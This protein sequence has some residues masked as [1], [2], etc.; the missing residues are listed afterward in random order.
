LQGRSGEKRKQGFYLE[1]VFPTGEKEPRLLYLEVFRKIEVER[2][3][4]DQ[5]FYN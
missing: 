3:K 2:L 1:K 4:D 5:G